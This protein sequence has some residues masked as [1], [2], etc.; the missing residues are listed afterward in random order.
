MLLH[1]TTDPR[2]APTPAIRA[3]S[4]AA[5]ESALRQLQSYRGDPIATIDAAI[6]ADPDFVMGHIL[7]AE[8]CITMWERGVLPEVRRGL[9]QLER[10]APSATDRERMHIAAIRDWAAGRLG[11]H[12]RA[13]RSA[14][15][16]LSR[17]T[18]WPCRSATSPTSTTAIATTCAAASPACCRRGAATCRA[19]GSCSACWRSGSRSAATTAAPRRPGRHAI[20]L[21]PDDCWAQH[22]V[23]HVMEMQSRQAEG[24]RLDGVAPASPLGAGRQRLRVPQL[25]AHGALSPGSG[26]RR[27]RA[28]HLRR[29]DPA[30]A[31]QGAAADARCGGAAVAAAPAARRRRQPLDRAGRHL[32]GRRP[33]TA[34]TPSTTCTR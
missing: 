22:A 21:E 8:V 12:A 27:S 26:A 2:G 17:P 5:F 34:S 6:A 11:G 4:A 13:A 20:E 9:E 19:M 33:R 3:E 15:R 25:V 1:A 24:H 31:H 10:L 16:R 30:G 7:R 23:T 14:A 32:R 28:R 18:C 29:L